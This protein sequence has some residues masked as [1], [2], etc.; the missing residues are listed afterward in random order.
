MP[1]NRE[2]LDRVQA[3]E[4]ELRIIRQRRGLV[5]IAVALVMV[6]CGSDQVCPGHVDPSRGQGLVI[7]TS[8]GSPTIASVQFKVDPNAIVGS[9]PCSYFTMDRPDASAGSGISQVTVTMGSSVFIDHAPPWTPEPAP[10]RMDVVSV[11]GQSG[12][13]RQLPGDRQFGWV[14]AN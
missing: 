6:C 3:L 8:D 10:C 5:G 1:R 14:I 11:D 9:S 7:R 4:D 2:V 13:D 12:F